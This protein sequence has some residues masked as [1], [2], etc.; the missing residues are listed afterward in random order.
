MPVHGT[1]QHEIHAADILNWLALLCKRLCQ[2]V[3]V[4][5]GIGR[6]THR[7]NFVVVHHAMLLQPH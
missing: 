1:G 6:L 5:G 4:L 7:S 2:T 3:Q